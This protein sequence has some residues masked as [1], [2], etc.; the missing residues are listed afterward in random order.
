[1]HR[2][3]RRFCRVVV[4]GFSVAVLVG[5][6]CSPSDDTS[7]GDTGADAG[8]DAATEDGA[9]TGTA[10]TEGH[11]DAEVTY[12][13]AV[14]PILD[15]HCSTCH[16]TGGVTPFPIET[17][18]DAVTYAEAALASVHAKTM[19]PWAPST[20]CNDYV[21]ERGLTEEQISTLDAWLDAGTPEGNAADEPPPLSVEVQALSRVDLRLTL[22]EP[23]VPQVSPD[24]YRC[25]VLDWPQE[26]DETVYVTGM[27]VAPGNAEIVHHVIAYIAPPDAR[28]EYAA[29]DEAD[30]G[31]GYTCFGGTG[32]SIVGS[33]GGWTPGSFGADTPQGTGHPIEPGSMIVMQMHYNTLSTDPAPDATALELKID[34]AVERPAFMMPVVNPGWLSDGGMPIPAGEPD[35]VHT[36]SLNPALFT[37]ATELT[38]HTALLH[39]HLLG[40]NARITLER[41]DG[42]R[43]CILAVDDWDFQWQDFYQ[44]RQPLQWQA[45]DRFGI[46]C[47]YDNTAENQPMVDGERL[48]PRDVQWGEGTTDEMCIG[49]MMV[50]GN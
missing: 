37:D 19:P 11:A 2:L 29:L 47:H 48:P 33:V 8:P 40:T 50:T 1:M 15:A 31:A 16:T 34:T 25:F 14:K 10:G 9:A 24:D 45:G 7:G 17:Y 43:E 18:Q 6:G 12:F 35:V 38:V 20:E 27:R 5:S 39:M 22:D 3:A 23:Y 4:A 46:E 42:S 36:A 30:P 44:L 32:G 28:A 21:A 49:F 13:G 41:Q 26:Y